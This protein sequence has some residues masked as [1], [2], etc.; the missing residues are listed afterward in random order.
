MFCSFDYRIVKF[1]VVFNVYLMSCFYHLW[2][3]HLHSFHVF[4]LEVT[5]FKT[6]TG[7]FS[8]TTSKRNK[9]FHI[10][11]IKQMYNSFISYVTAQI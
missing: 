9:E 5:P 6:H 4:D 2:V 11:F 8:H 3:Q 10:K 1:T 7:S